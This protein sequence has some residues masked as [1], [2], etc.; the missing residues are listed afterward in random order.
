LDAFKNFIKTTIVG[1]LI[2]L[3]PVIV[4]LL[5][6]KHALGFA[7][8][9]AKPI[10]EQFP[11]HEISGTAVATLV[12]IVI[13]ITLAFLA[14]LVSRTSYGRRIAHWFED[15][16]LGGMPQYRMMKTMAEGLA[17]VESAEGLLPVLVCGDD[18]WQLG[19][20]LEE[21]QDG[22]VVVFLPQA[23]TPMS[24]NILY[25]RSDRVQ[26]L[27]IGIGA[28]MK[29]VKRMG[30]GSAAALQGARLTPPRGV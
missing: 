19:Y 11:V 30:L 5:V 15:S 12:A 28:A 26:A 16:L 24:G 29:I 22:W 25:V 2:F 20:Q 17:Q 6:L 8:K 13:L 10:A 23:P 4:L 3:I 21:L 27:D 1:G 14:G 7:A 9:V 18:G